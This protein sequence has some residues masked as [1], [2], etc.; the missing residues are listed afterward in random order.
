M[1]NIEKGYPFFRKKGKDFLHFLK[2]TYWL[3]KGMLFG[4]SPR[5]KR[6]KKIKDKFATFSSFYF[7]KFCDFK[8]AGTIHRLINRPLIMKTNISL[9][10]GP[11]RRARVIYYTNV[12]N[13]QVQDLDVGL[14]RFG[15]RR[16][17]ICVHRVVII[18]SLHFCHIIREIFVS[19]EVQTAQEVMVSKHFL[20]T[21]KC[22]QPG[23]KY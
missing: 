6:V 20:I 13:F 11:T 5:E 23:R 16:V 9:H 17:F 8:I 14:D 18:T 15:T 22:R 10:S 2:I 19:V 7:K 12:S 3:K 21:L 4:L 1:T